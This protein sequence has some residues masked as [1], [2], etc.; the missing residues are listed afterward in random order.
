LSPRGCARFALAQG[1]ISDDVLGKLRHDLRT[2]IT[3]ILGYS[4][5]LL[6]EVAE[7]PAAP[8]IGDDLDRL[9]TAAREL[10]RV[11]EEMLE[12]ASLA[13]AEQLSRAFRTPLNAV[14]GYGELL[15]EDAA[16][17]P[18]WLLDD[19]DKIQAAGRVLVDLTDALVEL[20]RISDAHAMRRVAEARRGDVEEFGLAG[21]VAGV[22]ALGGH[23]LVVDDDPTSRDLLARLLVRLGCRVTQAEDG[24][25][26]LHLAA[27]GAVD[28]VLLDLLMPGLDGH[29]VCRRLR[30][31]PATCALPV[32]LLTASGDPEKIRALEAGADDFLPKP[33]DRAELMARVGSLLR[34][35]RHQDTIEHQKTEL[36]EWNR[37]LEA[38]VQEQ[39]DELQRLGRLRRYL[40]PQVAELIVASGSDGEAILGSHR[41]EV[42]VVFCDLR[43][44]TVLAEETEP[45]ELMHVL[46]EYHA[47]LGKQVH[48]FEGTLEHFAGDGV[49]IFFND[50]IAVEHHTARAVSMAV[51]MRSRMATLTRAWRKR[52][53]SLG[54]GVGIAVGEATLG[55]IGFEYRSDYAAIGRVTNLAAR[56]CA[57][58][59]AG[60]IILSE[61]AYRRVAERLEVE[62]VGNLDLKGFAWPVPAYN[63]VRH[64]PNQRC[65]SNQF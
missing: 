50:P 42:T 24:H 51:A 5:L 33:F 21:R 56:L 44:F 63:V 60:Q 6:E 43:G 11:V 9:H 64:R 62:L 40:A 48:R 47:T 57:E 49:M 17:G 65:S 46:R 35:K 19:L 15:S 36:A 13:D 8:P 39:V 34:I 45:A 53:H 37:T 10:L 26:A 7:A 1:P 25:A 52:G 31:N 59:T 18:P 54:F 4:E 12:P 61:R 23:V 41:R 27:T 3:H 30:A 29:E 32:V 22:G 14:L 38:R 20:L 16:G 55:T 28:L 58:A 2:P